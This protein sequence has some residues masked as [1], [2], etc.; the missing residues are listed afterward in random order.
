MNMMPT[1]KVGIGVITGQFSAVAMWAASEF[2]SV[3]LP[4][5]V[6]IS[7]AGALI[8]IVQWFVRDK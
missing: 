2:S 8:A 6:A 5:E 7:A 1:R 4:P 3:T